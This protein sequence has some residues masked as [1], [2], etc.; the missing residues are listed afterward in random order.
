VSLDG[1]RLTD[2]NDI[3]S[4]VW[5]PEVT[6]ENSIDGIA[7]HRTTNPHRSLLSLKYRIPT[8]PPPEMLLFSFSSVHFLNYCIGVR[9]MQ[10][11]TDKSVDVGHF[12]HD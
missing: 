2:F 7:Q 10:I 4:I 5:D 6:P 8:N 9:I 1:E 12:N 3:L 11:V